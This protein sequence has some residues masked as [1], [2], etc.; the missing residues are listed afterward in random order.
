MAID[1]MIFDVDG[2]LV[3]TNTAHVEAWVRAFSAFGYRVPAD[4]IWV[5]VGKGGDQLVP[6][7][8]GAEAASLHG[9]ALTR[10]QTYEFLAIARQRKFRLFPG[11]EELMVE[12]R[13]RGLRVALAT[14]S[15]SAHLDLTLMRVG[16]DL[17][18]HADVV[19]TKDDADASKPAPDL[20]LAAVRKLGLSPG[21]CAM[22]GDTVYDAEACRRAGVACIGVTSGGNS[23]EALF[24]AGMRTVC[25]DTSDVLAELDEVLETVA[26]GTAHLTYAFMERLMREALKEAKEGLV[27][28]EQ[29]F[30]GVLARGNGEIIARGHSEI[31]AWRDRTAHAVMVV[32]QR[33]AGLVPPDE[34]DLLL[35]STVEPCVMCTGAAIVATVDAVIYG[36]PVGSNG[37]IERVL[38]GKSPDSQP[39]RVIGPVLADESRALMKEWLARNPDLRRAPYLWMLLGAT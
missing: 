32:F 26:P 18:K 19:V 38:P 2:T 14:S 3:D 11:A 37:G 4:R 13:R 31:M 10:Q 1:A 24:Q 33:A 12:L 20:V 39:P 27:L 5:E 6:S 28:G 29:P 35:V 7:I 22:I 15:G 9:E 17:R 21:Q 23:R 25:E 16:V 36:M 8:L 34:R 30:G